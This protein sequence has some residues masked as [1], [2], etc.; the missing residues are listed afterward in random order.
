VLTLFERSHA[1][2]PIR[3]PTAAHF[4]RNKIPAISGTGHQVK[5]LAGN[6]AIPVSLIDI[7]R[8]LAPAFRE[9]V[10]VRV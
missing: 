9:P 2:P 10:A 4:D 7:R 6:L 5:K 1:D 8:F 3:F